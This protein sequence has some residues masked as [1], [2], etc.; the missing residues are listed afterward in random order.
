VAEPITGGRVRALVVRI[1][2]RPSDLDPGARLRAEVLDSAGHV[3]TS[4][5]RRLGVSP[6]P[7]AFTIPVGEIDGG[8]RRGQP[9][10]LVARVTLLAGSG[11]LIL[12]SD[13]KGRPSLSLVLGGDDRLRLVFVDGAQIYQRLDALPRIR[14]AGLAES[15]EDRR[16]QLFVLSGHVDPD[17]VVLNE[18]GPAGSGTDASLR[19]TQDDETQVRVRV[20]AAGSGYV[21]I[22]DPMQTGW[23]AF[24]DG[25]ASPLFPAEHALVAIHVPA[26]R[27]EVTVRYNPTSWRQGQLISGLSLLVLVAA[28]VY[29]RGKSRPKD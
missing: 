21:V 29:P 6:R 24:V 4:G 7:G 10:T 5:T 11:D 20:A 14:W 18:P 16:E 15:S 12:A 9:G 28:F 27:H 3:V 2:G 25:K 17:V 23:E 1:A 26:G 13:G 8:A 22:A 19:V